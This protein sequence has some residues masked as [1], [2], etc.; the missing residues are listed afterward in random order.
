MNKKKWVVVATLVGLLGTTAAA[1]ATGVF[2][3]VSGLIRSDIK[4]SVDGQAT[5]MQPVYING[6]AY[7]PVRDEAAALGYEVTY[8]AGNKTIELNKVPSS[9]SLS[10]G[11]KSEEESQYAHISGIVKSVKETEDGQYRLEVLGRGNANWIILYADKETVIQ[12]SE[13]KTVAAADL[14][15]GTEI[16]ADYGPV[17]AMSYPGQ[18]HAASIT[19]GLSR[20]VTDDT[21]Q[22]IEK[23]DEGYRVSLGKTENGTKTIDLV[24]NTGK[25]TFLMNEE[26]QP[27]E[28]KDLKEGAKVRAYYGPITTRSLPPQSPVFYLVVLNENGAAPSDEGSGATVQPLN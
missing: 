4:I 9:G 5:G 15:E 20:L 12:D 3:K 6:Q 19:V 14:K 24:L 10:N 25:E 26:G 21:I 16:N 28:W 17:V 8:N 27:V 2:G 7:L 22:S 11:T 1:Q 18:S 13:G 23:S